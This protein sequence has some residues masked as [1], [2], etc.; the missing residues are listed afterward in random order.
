MAIPSSALSIEAPLQRKPPNLLA[1]ISIAAVASAFAGIAREVIGHAIAD[2]LIGA[3][4]VSNSTFFAQ[5]NTPA[6]L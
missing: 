3:D 5:V 4:W 1:L 6:R 2:R